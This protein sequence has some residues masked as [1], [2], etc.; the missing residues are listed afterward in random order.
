MNTDRFTFP[1]GKNL[2]YWQMFELAQQY[3]S[4]E[5]PQAARKLG[6]LPAVVERYLINRRAEANRPLPEIAADLAEDMGG[7]STVLARY[8]NHLPDYPTLEEINVNGWNSIVLKYTDRPDEWLEETFLS[9]RHAFNILARLVSKSRTGVLNETTPGA[10]SYIVEGVRNTVLASPIA[11][12][13][14]GVYAS[15]RIVRPQSVSGEKL[16]DEGEL[17]PNMLELLVLFMLYGANMVFSGKP[18]AGKTALLNYLLSIVAKR[19]DVRIGTIEEGSRELTLRRFDAHG[20]PINQVLSLLT[21]PSDKPEQNYNPNKLLEYC[22]RY[23]LDYLVP[24][25]MRSEEA[26]SAQETARTGMAVHTTIHCAHAKAAYPRIVTLCQQRSRELASTLLGYAVE[27]FPVS[28]HLKYMADGKRRCME[29][30]E[31]EDVHDGIVKTRP[32]FRFAVKDNVKTEA[33]TRVVGQFEQ[34]GRLS[35]PLQETLLSNGA[36]LLSLQKFV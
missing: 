9:P 25:E 22:L 6:E 27:A 29:I 10:V 21:R 34:T 14:A 30:L 3:V 32:L 4:A 18:R 26:Y 13:D 28:V 12:K 17:S 20:R 19:R 5:N 2:T 16:L 24:Q 15:I 36:P 35:E 11:P 23:D 33:G 8:L 1:D 31:A 7:V